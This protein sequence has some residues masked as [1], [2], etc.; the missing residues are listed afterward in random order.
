[1]SKIL[2]AVVSL[3]DNPFPPQYRKL[4][5]AELIYRI[6]IGDYRVIYQVN[7]ETKCIVIYHI[8]HRKDVYRK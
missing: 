5:G 3:S 8:R 7:T 6:R 2:E 4:H 1:M